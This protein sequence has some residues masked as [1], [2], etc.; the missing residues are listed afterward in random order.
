MVSSQKLDF[1]RTNLTVAEA[2]WN[3]SAWPAFV[4]LVEHPF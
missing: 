1:K 2:N 4:L 3:K